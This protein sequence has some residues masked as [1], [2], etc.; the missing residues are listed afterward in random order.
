LGHLDCGMTKINLKDFK[1]RLTLPC[2][3]FICSHGSSYYFNEEVNPFYEL[4]MFFKLFNDELKNIN[5]QA[6]RLERFRGFPRDIKIIK[7]LYDVETGMIFEQEK[8]KKFVFME[9][10]KDEYQYILSNKRKDFKQFLVKI[11]DEIQG[12]QTIFSKNRR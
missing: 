11:E 9:K 5:D 7:M 12:F 2:L 8:I 10:F 1:K 3:S 4:R 6:E